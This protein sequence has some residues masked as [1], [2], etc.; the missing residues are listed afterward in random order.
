VGKKAPGGHNILSLKKKTAPIL[1]APLLVVPQIFGNSGSAHIFFSPVYLAE[2]KAALYKGPRGGI[3]GS[4]LHRPGENFLY[5]APALFLTYNQH[6]GASLCGGRGPPSLQK[7]ETLP[8]PGGATFAPFHSA[9]R[10][11]L[12]G[13]NNTLLDRSLLRG[14]SGGVYSVSSFS[15]LA[16]PSRGA[17]L[18]W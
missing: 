3:R 1:V 5:R 10:P 18:S 12:A 13:A 6:R 14:T 16:T 4:P 2:K 8:T 9:G 11:F 17:P 7:L 15:P